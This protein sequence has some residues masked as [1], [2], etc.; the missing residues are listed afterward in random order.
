M[1]AGSHEDPANLL[2]EPLT[3][4]EQQVLDMLVEGLTGGEMAERLSLA[5][6]SVRWYVQQLY[7]KLGGE[8]QTAGYYA[9]PRA[10]AAAVGSF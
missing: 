3:R 9:R 6:S 10:G 8:R 2:L 5:V 7:G 4:R 1:N